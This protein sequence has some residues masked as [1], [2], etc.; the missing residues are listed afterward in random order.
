MPSLA[1]L[2]LFS[3]DMAVPV[4]RP[5][6]ATRTSPARGF[7]LIELLIVIAIIGIIAAIALPLFAGLEQR[8]RIARAQA[9]LRT[10]ASAVSMYDAHMGELPAVVDDL[11]VVA[12]NGLGQVA[13]PFLADVPT[14]P[15][16]AWT[17]YTYA[18]DLT[19]GTFT[20]TA[21]GDGATVSVP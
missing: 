6:L 15:S 7:T 12:T 17:P 20:I 21:S 13:G 11:T 4:P 2:L 9:D 18:V 10:M 3:R 19:A 8:G 14:R 1:S 5:H 16:A